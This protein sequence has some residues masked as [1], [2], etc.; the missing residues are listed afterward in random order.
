MTVGE[1]L[2]RYINQGTTLGSVNMP[3]VQLRSLTLDEP[4]VARVRQPLIY[5]YLSKYLTSSIGHLYPPE[6]SWCIE[7]RSVLPTHPLEAYILTQESVNEI[8]GDHNV[9][10][11]T[12]DSRGDVSEI[13]VV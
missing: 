13:S 2:V 4:N 11:Q 6:R 8:L 9:D 5:L 3:E 12:S 1:A 7:E 10:K